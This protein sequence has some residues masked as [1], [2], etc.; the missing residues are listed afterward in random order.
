MRSVKFRNALVADCTANSNVM[1]R[2]CTL[3]RT[4]TLQ[5]VSFTSMEDDT[6]FQRYTFDC[7]SN[8]PTQYYDDSR[9]F[10]A[11]GQSRSQYLLPIQALPRTIAARESV[12]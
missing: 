6:T 9:I 10:S 7:E 3:P 1:I 11:T 2:L 12:K 4:T 5:H 8:N